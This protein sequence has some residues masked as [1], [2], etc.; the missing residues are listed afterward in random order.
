MQLEEI[1][2]HNLKKPWK[3]KFPKFRDSFLKMAEQPMMTPD[4]RYQKLLFAREQT[5][6]A[7]EEYNRCLQHTNVARFRWEQCLQE[8]NRLGL[9]ATE[10]FVPDQVQQVVQQEEVVVQVPEVV[11][12]PEPET[13]PTRNDRPRNDRPR[14]DRSRNESRNSRNDRSRNESKPV[15][16]DAPKQTVNDSLHVCLNLAELGVRNPTETDIGRCFAEDI[17]FRWKIVKFGMKKRGEKDRPEP[18]GWFN[19]EFESEADALEAKK[20]IETMMTETDT[21]VYRSVEILTRF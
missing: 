4:E 6:K 1:D 11:E 7:A 18:A 14:N 20:I 10:G 12:Q 8:E 3:P 13:K 9:N 19:V 17:D 21:C 5:V 16:G 15:R 2:F